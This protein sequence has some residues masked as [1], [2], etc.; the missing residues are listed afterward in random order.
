MNMEYK[1]YVANVEFDDEAGLF[2]GVVTNTHD[3]ITFQGDSESDL[4]R[5]FIDSIEDY[6]AFCATRG[7]KPEKPYP[8]RS[9]SATAVDQR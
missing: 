9:G 3:V 4:H 2:H 7:E 1:G 6:L 8:S 5:A